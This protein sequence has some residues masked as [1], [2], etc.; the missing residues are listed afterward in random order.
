MDISALGS[1]IWGMSSSCGRCIFKELCQSKLSGFLAYVYCKTK[2]EILHK[3]AHAGV[4]A[5]Q[6]KQSTK[7]MR[8][9]LALLSGYFRASSLALLGSLSLLLQRAHS[10]PLDRVLLAP[11]LSHSS[12]DLWTLSSPLD[13]LSASAFSVST[14][15]RS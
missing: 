1:A 14:D 12:I 5:S 3:V 4:S 15:S 11:W 2:K 6:N 9:Y 10:W 8:R 7:K 13:S